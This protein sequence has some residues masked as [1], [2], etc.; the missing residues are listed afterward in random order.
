MIASA[1]G[2]EP[3]ELA[4][5]GWRVRS[6]GLAAV[7]GESPSPQ[8]VQVAAEFDC[9]LAGH[10]SRPVDPELLADATDVI[11]VTRGH[12]AALAVYFY[13]VG[14]APVLLGGPDGDL[15]DPIGGDATEY[16]RCAEAIEAHLTRHLA[17]WLRP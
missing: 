15:P 16:R 1:L 17:E 4:V 2:C 8:A 13:G 12:A 7:T 6:A 5:R 3:A 11:A 9:D 14:P 10:R